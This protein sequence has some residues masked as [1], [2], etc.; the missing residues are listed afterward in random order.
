MKS[1]TIQFTFTPNATMTGTA[2]IVSNPIPLDQIYGF[3]I[4]AFWTGSPT[5]TLKLQASSDSP[6]RETQTS[7]G[8]P[9]AVT[10]WS[11]V[12]NSSYSITGSAGNYMW[13]FNG[14]FYRYVR[15]SYT[16]ISGT[17]TMAAEISAKGA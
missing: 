14:A 1:N 3:A 2:T 11:D 4:Q 10:N 6:G 13:N 15:I 7:S 17:G 16:N 12:T 5:G 8:G 9:D